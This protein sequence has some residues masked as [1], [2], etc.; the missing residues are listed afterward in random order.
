VTDDRGDEV[1]NLRFLMPMRDPFLRPRKLRAGAIP[2]CGD[3]KLCSS[4]MLKFA[5]EV[6][7][8]VCKAADDGFELA[9]AVGDDGMAIDALVGLPLRA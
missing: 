9:A 1:T 6:S 2:V 8:T 4:P 3:A 5:D 7:V